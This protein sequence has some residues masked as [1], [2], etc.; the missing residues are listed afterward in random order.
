MEKGSPV[1]LF[2]INVVFM[3]TAM[4]LITLGY[5][6][7]VKD[8]YMG[9]LITEFLIIPGP[10]LLYVLWKGVRLQGAFNLRP[11]GLR[12]VWR[13]VLITLSAYPV[14]LF[15]NLLA[16]LFLGMLGELKPV[17]IPAAETLGGYFINILVIA[18]V[19]GIAEELFFRGFL[20]KGYDGLSE[21]NAIIISAALFGVFH[22]NIQNFLGPVFLGIIFGCLAMRTGSVI[23]PIVG[24]FVNNALSV[25]CMFISEL[26]SDALP[27][28]YTD[29]TETVG[30]LK[31]GVVFW[32]FMALIGG[33]AT[34]KLFNSLGTK[35]RQNRTFV[36]APS[37]KDFIPVVII[38]AIFIVFCI[39]ELI[40]I[41]NGIR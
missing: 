22:F 5:H 10:A 41:I 14:G 24:H 36:A 20:L 21:K 11:I 34:L 29:P 13:C 7:Q 37:F 3:I 12:I 9:L 26:S 38:I 40:T 18:L 8:I 15:L 28:G 23:G 32:G 1:T 2:G 30:L 27:Q 33:I 25:T 16:S 31:S 17:P 19:A 6:Y 4:L 35:Y 39:F